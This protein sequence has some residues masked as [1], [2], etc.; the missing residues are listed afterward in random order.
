MGEN[1]GVPSTLQPLLILFVKGFSVVALG[2]IVAVF[3]ILHHAWL[4]PIGSIGAGALIT[5]SAISV[6]ALFS[7]RFFLSLTVAAII[8]VLTV[9]SGFESGGSILIFADRSGFLFLVSAALGLV[10]SIAWP[11]IHPRDTGYDR[12]IASPER[13]SQP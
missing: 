1:D 8:V 10:T 5:L 13:I 12:G 4:F 7:S 2:T 11:R 3:S 9:A 6:R